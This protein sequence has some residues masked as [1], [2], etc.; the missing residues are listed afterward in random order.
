METLKFK[1]IIV[2]IY[3]IHAVFHSTN[4]VKK[5]VTC[6]YFEIY[7]LGKSRVASYSICPIKFFTEKRVCNYYVSY[8]DQLH[9]YQII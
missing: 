8:I 5:Y 9:D 3:L 1:D 4:I 6:N 2:D 7:K